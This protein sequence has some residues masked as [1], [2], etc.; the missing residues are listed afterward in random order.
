MLKYF[1]KRLLWIIPTVLGVTLIV[2][3]LLEFTPGDPARQLLG[4]FATEE[5]IAI[6]REEMGLNK[7]ILVRYVE[8]IAGVFKGDIGQ[9]YFTKGAVWNEVITKFPYTLRLVSVSMILSIFIG[10]K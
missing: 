3:L 2:M 6:A 10:R 5:D 8:Y 1:L 4:N 7:N 9:S